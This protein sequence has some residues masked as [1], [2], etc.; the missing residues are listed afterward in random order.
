MADINVSLKSN[1]EA[2]EE[3]Y[4]FSAESKGSVESSPVSPNDPDGSHFE[5]P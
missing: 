4:K 2:D 3:M 5:K 1:S